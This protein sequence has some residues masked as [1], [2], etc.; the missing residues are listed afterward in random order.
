MK[1][2]QSMYDE[3]GLYFSKTR[4]KT[5]GETTNNWPITQKYLEMVKPGGSVLDV[6]CG[7]GRLVSGLPKGVSYYGFDFSKTLLAQAKLTYPKHK[8]EYGDAVDPAVWDKLPKF[9]AVFCVA[10]I[11]H[12]PERKHQLYLLREMKKHV[13]PGGLL[14][15]TTWNLWQERMIQKGIERDKLITGSVVEMSFNKTPGRYVVA[16]DLPYLVQLMS[17]AG[18]S[19]ERI[20]YSDHEGQ[21]TDIQHGSNLV[22]IARG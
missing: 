22:A 16:M 21:A 12:L 20:C 18:W 6:G 11:H 9:E 15:I 5:Y 17:E 2:V 13:K 14:F 8:F 19:V 7:D 1:Q 4:K 3:T 10:V